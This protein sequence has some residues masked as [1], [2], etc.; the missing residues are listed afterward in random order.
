M[1][2]RLL[3]CLVMGVW[4]L[5]SCSVDSDLSADPPEKYAELNKVDMSPASF[6]LAWIVDRQVVDT[7][8]FAIGMHPGFLV[9]T[10]FPI[11]YFLHLVGVEVDPADISYYNESYW[12]MDVSLIGSSADNYYLSNNTWAPRTYFEMNGIDYE[13]HI[14]LNTD[15]MP[16]MQTALMYDA[17]KDVWSGTA[18]VDSY[19]ILNLQ[20][21]DE[22]W[23]REFSTPLPLIYQTTASKN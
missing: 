12:L 20:N 14:F 6:D 21:R 19:R 4:V 1:K 2:G 10:H 8:T 22:F 17:Q 18:S 13:F 11:A 3:L 9:V 7:A 5:A 16:G 15:Q 23:E